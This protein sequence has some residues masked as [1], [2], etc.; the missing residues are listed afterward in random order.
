MPPNH[1]ADK[2][3]PPRDPHG[4]EWGFLW[5]L[6]EISRRGYV[7]LGL[8]AERR[9]EVLEGFSV[10]LRMTG[11]LGALHDVDAGLRITGDQQ[12][13]LGASVC[14]KMTMTG[15]LEGHLRTTLRERFHL[16]T[17]LA[18]VHG[19]PHLAVF[20]DGSEHEVRT[21]TVDFAVL[22]HLGPTV[23]FPDLCWLASKT[24]PS[25]GWDRIRA[26][27][28]RTACT[29]AVWGAA[30]ALKNARDRA[31]RLATAA[32]QMC[33]RLARGDLD[34]GAEALMLRDPNE[35]TTALVF[36]ALNADWD[37]ERWELGKSARAE[38]RAAAM[39]PGYWR[40]RDGRE[41]RLTDNVAPRTAGGF[42]DGVEAND[43]LDKVR[44]VCPPK[45]RDLLDLLRQDPGL[46]DERDELAGLL[47]IT[48]NYLKQLK[49][50]LRKVGADVAAL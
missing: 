26:L 19:V 27:D 47:G 16:L 40:A 44:S 8:L 7:P 25:A 10:R 32:Q 49:H 2:L 5:E 50:R 12:S 30:D 42:A 4:T 21:D 28:W 23:D 22:K 35:W 11:N 20:P 45:V 34:S 37:V 43:L 15:T 1:A 31:Q 14:L 41:L 33:A 36:V 48:P 38:A 17:V 6:D 46:L 9:W 24:V 13:Q 29:F 3:S 39:G 18:S